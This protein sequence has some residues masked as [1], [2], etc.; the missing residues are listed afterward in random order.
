VIHKQSKKKQKRSNMLRNQEF[1]TP[2]AIDEGDKAPATPQRLFHDDDD[3]AEP[4][5]FGGGQRNSPSSSSSSEDDIRARAS[6]LLERG[7]GGGG[8]HGSNPNS[9]Y[10]PNVSSFR[11]TKIPFGNGGG[12][13]S[14][15]VNP[16]DEMF[17]ADPELPVHDQLPSVGTCVWR[18]VS[19]VCGGSKY[20]LVLLFECV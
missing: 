14:N 4:N 17:D 7:G 9:G 3:D 11:G 10:K 12:T 5:V 16:Q 6:L 19:F 15:T 8:G 13:S 20:I 1:Q 2:N 18:I